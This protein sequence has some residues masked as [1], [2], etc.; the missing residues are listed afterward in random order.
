[1]KRNNF[2]TKD[3]DFDCVKMQRVI[4]DELSKRWY[5]HPELMEKD[6]ETIHKK[7]KH[8]FNNQPI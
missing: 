1:M 4:R 3:K 5:K 2:K 6:L 7:Y 8:L